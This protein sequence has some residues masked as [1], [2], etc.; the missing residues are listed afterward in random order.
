MDIQALYHLFQAT[1]Q[2]DTNVRIQ[3]EL[4]L[5][6]VHHSPDRHIQSDSTQ[7][8]MAHVCWLILFLLTLYPFFPLDL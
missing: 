5:K 8:S 2:P 7:K 4:Q 6:Q 1:L 3:A